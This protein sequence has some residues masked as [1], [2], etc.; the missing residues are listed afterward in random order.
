[1]SSFKRWEILYD[2]STRS[3][4]QEVDRFYKIE[5]KISKFI[6]VVT[7]LITIFIG[8]LGI[9]S[10]DLLP[11]NNRLEIFLVILLVF[12]FISLCCVWLLLFK[13]LRLQK[14]KRVSLNDKFIDTFKKE[15]NPKALLW[16]LSI[17]NINLNRRYRTVNTIKLDL[18]KRSYKHTI[19]SSALI[20][21]DV[22]ILAILKILNTI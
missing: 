11:I 17:M 2:Y 16:Y 5:D 6:S 3:L 13:G 18:L 9:F 7:L 1:M 12:T 19:T 21:A 10:D 20:V 14:V 4:D 8:S 22:L 15:E